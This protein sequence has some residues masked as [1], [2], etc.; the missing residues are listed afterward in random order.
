MIKYNSK[1]FK[2]VFITITVVMGVT[3]FLFHSV[4]P[5]FIVKIKNPVVAILKPSFKYPTSDIN[6]VI[7][8]TKDGINLVGIHNEAKIKRKGA[9]ILLHGIRAG[10]EHFN[11]ISEFLSING[12]DTFAF[13]SR[14]HGESG[15]EYCTFGDK[16]KEDVSAIVDYIFSITG[17]ENISV[18]GQSLG[19]AIGIQALASDKRLRSGII[20][21]TF[22]DFRTIVHDYAKDFAGFEIPFLTDYLIDRAGEI[23]GFN[24]D[25]LSPLQDCKKIDQPMLIVHGNADEKIDESYGKRNFKNLSSVRK[26]FIEINYAGHLNVWEKGGTEYLENVVKFLDSNKR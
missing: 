16:E 18:W 22:S 5:T 20:E 6:K 23:A 7:I 19:G 11:K 12:Y 13:D 14:G 17:E 26:E 4:F 25:I 24:P 15:G 9:V 21:S 10:K 2:K 8:K 1:N 3:V